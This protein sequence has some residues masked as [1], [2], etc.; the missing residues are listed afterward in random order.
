MIVSHAGQA[1]AQTDD[2]EQCREKDQHLRSFFPRRP[3][4]QGRAYRQRQ[5]AQRIKGAPAVH[6]PKHRHRAEQGKYRQGMGL[7]IQR[8]PRD[9]GFIVPLFMRRNGDVYRSIGRVL[10]AVCTQNRSTVHLL[11]DKKTVQKIDHFTGRGSTPFRDLPWFPVNA[12]TGYCRA[13]EKAP[14][15]LTAISSAL[16]MS[17]VP[18]VERLSDALRGFSVSNKIFIRVLRASRSRKHYRQCRRVFP[19]WEIRNG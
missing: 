1:A 16:L 12:V 13:P 2:Q 14:L 9:H 10:S 4:A 6:G 18:L 7:Y 3:D 11:N 17:Q 5:D 8:A 15:C 19:R